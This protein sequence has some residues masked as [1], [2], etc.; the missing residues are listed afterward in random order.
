MK[1]PRAPV[2]RFASA[3]QPAQHQFAVPHPFPRFLRKWVGENASADRP[4]QSLEIG[5][6]GSLP[7]G[8]PSERFLLDGVA[9][10]VP[11][12]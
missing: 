3:L 10:G 2:Q 12:E 1:M 9:A 6:G 7:A 4:G 8:A 5:L 11:S